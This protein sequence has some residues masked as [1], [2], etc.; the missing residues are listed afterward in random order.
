MMDG[1]SAFEYR[2]RGHMDYMLPED[3]YDSIY[4]INGF[5]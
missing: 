3:Y 1:L 2:L 4:I 5:M